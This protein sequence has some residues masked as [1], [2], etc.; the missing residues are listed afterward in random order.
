MPPETLLEVSVDPSLPEL[1]GRGEAGY[2]SCAMD[3]PCP[4]N[5]RKT[6]ALL[7]T[8]RAGDHNNSP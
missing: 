2:P 7:H 3:F 5:L 8:N 4:A 1:S 6:E